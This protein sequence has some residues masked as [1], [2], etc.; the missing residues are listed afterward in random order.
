MNLLVEQLTE[1]LQR[2]QHKCGLNLISEEWALSASHCTVSSVN[3]LAFNVDMQTDIDYNEIHYVAQ[4]GISLVLSPVHTK[5]KRKTK[6]NLS[7]IFVR[8]SFDLCRLFFD[9]FR[10]C[11]CFLLV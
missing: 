1:P 2:I 4:V 3:G 11:F 8:Y 10:F 7:L 6:R 9:L 5:G